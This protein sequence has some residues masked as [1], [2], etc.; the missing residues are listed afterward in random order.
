MIPYSITFTIVWTMWLLIWVGAGLS[1]GIGSELWY[2]PP[3]P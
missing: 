1:L 3:T 2:Q